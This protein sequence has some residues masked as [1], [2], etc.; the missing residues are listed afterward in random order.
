MSKDTE[1]KGWGRTLL[2]IAA[3]GLAVLIPLGWLALKMSRDAALRKVVNS[4][5]AAAIYT[6]EQIAAA[7]QLYF[8]TYEQQYATLRQLLDAGFF[9]APLDGE[10]LAAHGYT[11]TLKIT[12]KTEAQAAAYSVNAD[13]QQEGA[14]G[15]RHFYFD[16][17]VTGIRVS[18][19]RPATAADPPR[20][21]VEPY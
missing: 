6:L 1:T 15:N 21:S 16:S 10:Q 3:V 19:G 7:E 20:Q 17:N 14:T 4:N 8:Q 5:E 2:V 11:F 13:P 12:P 18:E 9:K